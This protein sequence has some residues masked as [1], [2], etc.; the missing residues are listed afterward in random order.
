MIYNLHIFHGSG[1]CIFSLNHD[2]EHHE[3]TTQMLYGF[4]WSLKVRVSLLTSLSLSLLTILFT[5]FLSLLCSPSR[6]ASVQ[7]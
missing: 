5:L 6:T 2:D 7:S 4:L 1:N 3:N